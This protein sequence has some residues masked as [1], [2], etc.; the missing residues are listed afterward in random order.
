[1]WALQVR[2]RL[3]RKGRKV[4]YVVLAVVAVALLA[5]FMMVRRR[6]QPVR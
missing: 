3:S 6:K 2:Q 1:M 4:T 5:A